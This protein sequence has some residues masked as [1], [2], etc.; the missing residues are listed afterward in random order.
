MPMGFFIEEFFNVAEQFNP[1][2]IT[3]EEIGIFSAVLLM[4]PG[5]MFSNLFI[6]IAHSADPDQTTPRGAT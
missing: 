1:I 2:R 5:T 4:C 6:G 3:D